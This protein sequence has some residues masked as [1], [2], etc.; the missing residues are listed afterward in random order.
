[1]GLFSVCVNCGHNSEDHSREDGGC[2]YG[3]AQGGWICRCRGYSPEIIGPPGY[4]G[5]SA[6]GSDSFKEIRAITQTEVD[7]ELIKEALDVLA[8]GAGEFVKEALQAHE[9]LSVL[10]LGKG[11]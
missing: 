6:I 1:M 4:Q 2:V 8:V 9:R 5:Q 10:L 3:L 11:K 7:L